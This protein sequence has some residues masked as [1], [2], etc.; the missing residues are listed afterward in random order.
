V[1]IA[2]ATVDAWN[3]GALRVPRMDYPAYC[4]A[5]DAGWRD[6]LAG[7]VAGLETFVRVAKGSI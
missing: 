6:V 5:V 3:A 1:P 4:A 2:D 7:D